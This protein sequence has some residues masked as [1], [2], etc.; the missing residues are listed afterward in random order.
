MI[1]RPLLKKCLLPFLLFPLLSHLALGG[2]SYW[3]QYVHYTMDVKL[4]T[5]AHTIGGNS[6]IVYVN[7]SPDTLQRIDMH[8][9]PNAF[10]EGSV[11][12]RGYLQGSGCRGRAAM[13]IQEN[14]S[15]FRRVE[16]HAFSITPGGTVWTR[17]FKVDDTILSADLKHGLA[18]GDSILIDLDW[19]HHIGEQVERAGRVGKQYN[20]AQWY[21][22]MVVY[23]EHGWN[24]MPFH[25]EGEFYGEFSTFDV[26]IDVPG[27]YIVGATGI[28]TD[29]DSGW[30]SVRVDTTQPF[31]E[32]L[33]NFKKQST[34]PDSTVRR[35]VSFHAENVHDF[36]WIASPDFL[37]EEGEWNGIKVHVLFNRKNGK[38][39]TKKVVDRTEWTL[40]W[41]SSQFGPYPYPQVTTTDRLKGG[42]MEYPMLVMNGSESEGLIVHEVGHI[43]FYGILGNNEVREAWLDEGFT[44][45]QTRWYL[46]RK[47]GPQ[48]YDLET[49]HLKPWQ[50]K[51]WKFGSS[52][53]RS[54]WYAIRYLTSGRDEPI[55][56]SS[57]MFRDGWGYSMNAYTKPSLMLDELR[58][59]LGDS[60]FLAGMREYY[61]RWQ[62]KHPNEQRFIQAMEAVS[63]EDLD[64]FFRPWLHNTRLLDYGIERWKKS[65]QPDGSWKVTLQIRRYGKRELPQ[66]VEVTLEDGTTYR[67]WWQNHQWRQEDE[68]VF[69]V[70]IEPVKAVLDPEAR[71]LDLDYRNNGTGRMPTEFF[72]YRPGMNYAPRNR[73]ILQWFPSV[74]YHQRDGFLPGVWLTRDYGPWEHLKGGVN[75]GSGKVFWFAEGWRRN[76]LG[77]SATTIA[78]QVASLGALE[79]AGFQISRTLDQSFHFLNLDRLTWSVFYV[80]VVDTNRTDLFEGGRTTVFSSRLNT[81]TGPLRSEMQ[82]DLAPGGWSDWSFARIT[83]ID[84]AEFRHGKFGLRGRG[85]AGVIWAGSDGVPVQERYTVEGA[86]SGG[87]YRKSYL[88]DRSSF[89]GQTRLRDQYHLPGDVNLRAF[90]GKGY[91]GVKQ[92]AS[93]SL[94]GF[95][96]HRLAGLRTELAL[97]GDAGV[98]NDSAPFG[99]DRTFANDV[100]M[101]FGFGLRLK[102]SVF[103]QELYLRLD[104]PWYLVEAGRG[105]TD[106]SNLIFSFQQGL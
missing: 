77:D 43:W 28:V 54:Q 96:N 76:P 14:E 66:Q 101:D 94:E 92:A 37:Y 36:A 10:Q 55:S 98:L 61:R 89:Y 22:K 103:G 74:Q 59:V 9:Y 57:Y 58:Y 86:G 49:A 4:D 42:G 40:E 71:T 16:I 3:Q 7:Y 35:R 81:H 33:K 50:K 75:V 31:E 69:T 21:P 2:N 68:F 83:L 19:T 90:A 12:Q 44:T 13:F 64:W 5:S 78:Y 17:D 29:G 26:T 38:K 11:N 1:T 95:F 63:G 27:G 73:Y 93:V 105:T 48:G 88:R 87:T 52:L 56:R 99:K 82:V 106:F 34:P 30:E 51:Y 46:M 91:P 20:L 85:M 47:Y 24:E 32:W 97:F 23:D 70:P 39:W 8:L 45:F 100:L 18:P 62:L 6:R 41:L 67:T 80:N 104:L 79:T 53:G 102:T 72:F 65:R 84:R 15:Y 60:L 25:A